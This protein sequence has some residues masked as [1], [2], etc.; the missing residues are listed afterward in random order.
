MIEK[1]MSKIEKKVLVGFFILFFIPI[2]FVQSNVWYN[3]G[4]DNAFIGELM[5]EMVTTG[6]PHIQITA[7]FYH[8]F[9]LC[10]MKPDEVLKQKLEGPTPKKL[11]QFR[12]HT[13]LILYPLSLFT[14]VIPA[15]YLIPLL[16]VCSFLVLIFLIY[17]LARSYNIDVITSVMVSLFVSIHPAWSWGLFYG[18]MYV[19]RLFLPLGLLFI[20]LL[21]KKDIPIKSLIFVVFLCALISERV[22][23]I[24]GIAIL[25]QLVFNWK[26][27]NSTQRKQLISIAVVAIIIT[28]ALLKL[29]IRNSDYS[30]FSSS[31][32]ISGF[33]SLLENFPG[34]AIKLWVFIFLNIIIYGIFGCFNWKYSLI[35]LGVMLPNVMGNIGGAEKTGWSTHYHT[36]YF[37][38]LAFTVISGLGVLYNKLM[39]FKKPKLNLILLNLSIIGLFYVVASINLTAPLGFDFSKNPLKRSAFALT[40]DHMPLYMEGGGFDV[41]VNDKIKVD[42]S[43]PRGVVVTTI[44]HMYTAL[45]EGREM[46]QYPAGVGIADYVVL[47]HRKKEPRFFGAVNY[48]GPEASNQLDI[49]LLVR[50]EEL[51]FDLD[52]PT[53]IGPWAILKKKNK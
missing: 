2:Y 29:Y 17:A 50:L 32:S 44:S 18:E 33:M 37:P 47:P 5:N 9:K 48:N 20:M 7:G 21:N 22:G 19:D 16:K 25:G 28:I 40:L 12:K 4:G 26:N 42:E 1:K 30:S 45:Y 35:T 31:F 27:I 34:F 13:Y 23:A 43:I 10:A 24:C 11:N 53:I 39:Q 51:N 15:K 36:L 41:L 14:K 52:N 3:G 49:G 8:L 6:K 38:F 46:Y